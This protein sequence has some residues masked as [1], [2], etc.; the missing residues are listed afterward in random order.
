MK[1]PNSPKRGYS[2]QEIDK[3]LNAI[4]A[5]HKAP[6]HPVFSN[7]VHPDTAEM[8]NRLNAVEKSAKP[9]QGEVLKNRG[10]VPMSQ[11]EFKKRLG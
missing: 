2:L 5:Q 9:T 4:Y 8:S 7:R 10:G 6:N 1:R 11:A 3:S